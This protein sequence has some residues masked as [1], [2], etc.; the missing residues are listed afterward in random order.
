MPLASCLLLPG[1]DDHDKIFYTY[2]VDIGDSEPALGY[3]PEVTGE[4]KLIGLCW[5]EFSKMSERS[6]AFLWSAGIITIKEFSDELQS[7]SDD[8]SYPGKVKI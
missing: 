8:V 7:Y 6:R 5:C 1:A 2:Q 4:P 3:D